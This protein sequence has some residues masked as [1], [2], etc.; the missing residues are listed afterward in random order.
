MINLKDFLTESVFNDNDVIS[1]S[2]ISWFK[3]HT[4]SEQGS[5]EFIKENVYVK[6]GKLYIKDNIPQT[7]IIYCKGEELPFEFGDL[8]CSL[9]L[10]KCVSLKGAPERIDGSFDV[11]FDSNATSLKGF[12]KHIS[13]N[14]EVSLNMVTDLTGMPEY[15][16][17][18]FRLF[19]GYKIKKIDKLPKYVG[20]EFAFY[21]LTELEEI[22]DITSNGMVQI[23]DCGKLKK[24]GN[25]TYKEKGYLSVWGCR[26]LQEIGDVD[27]NK[28]VF[29]SLEV[30]PKLRKLPHFSKESKSLTLSGLNITSLEGCPETVYSSVQIKCPKLTSLE[31]LPKVIHGNLNLKGCRSLP[32]SEIENAKNNTEYKKLTI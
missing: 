27:C 15:V 9:D 13:G 25:I 20:N 26:Q 6:N 2:I 11:E 1:D 7:I 30:L 8:K 24:V 19:D 3:S 17:G 14:V 5:D 10:N 22:T 18:W 23:K 31:G 32:D 21:Y 29:I 12:P 4:N 16:G 28:N